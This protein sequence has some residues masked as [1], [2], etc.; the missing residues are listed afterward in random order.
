MK[1]IIYLIFVLLFLSCNKEHDENGKLVPMNIFPS[2]SAKATKT[3]VDESNII[4]QQIGIQVTN[5]VGSEF[6]DAQASYNNI[7]LSNTGLWTLDSTVY[8][9]NSSAKI[10]AYSPYSL[11]AGDLTG[12]GSSE[13]PVTRLLNIPASLPME[14]QI[15]YLWAA[16]EKTTFDGSTNINNSSANVTL[17]MNHSLAQI[18]FV[19]YKENYKGNGIISR[20]KIKDNSI[21]P[22]LRMNKNGENDLRMRLL[23]GAITGGQTSSELSVTE[24]YKTI[25]LTTDPGIDP[26]ILSNYISGYLLVVPTSI[27]EQ[28]NM[29]F[30]F[31][32]DGDDYSV[33]LGEGI[34]NWQQGNQYIYK[35]KLAAN[36][37]IITGLSV[38]SWMSNC[39]IDLPTEGG[40][41][42]PTA[43]CYIIA[44]N[45]SITIPV[46]I[47]G[48]GS[49]STIEQGISN[50]HNAHSM[51]ILWSTATN[52]I[53]LQ[54]FNITDQ[55]I[56]ISTSNAVGNALIAA[57]DTDDSTILWSWHIWVTDYDPNNGGTTY[58]FANSA[59]IT[60]TFMDR[61][62][63]ALSTSFIDD[64]NNLYYQFGRKDPFPG[65]NYS[66]PI[67]K[68]VPKPMIYA[69]Q[70]PTTFIT[71][72]SEY[73]AIMFFWCSTLSNDW[74]WGI[75][76]SKYIPKSKTIYD[77]CPTGWRVPACTE[78]RSPWDN[79]TDIN[80]LWENN[81]WNWTT[82]YNAGSYPA[83]GH[84]LGIDGSISE[85][86][87]SGYL[88]SATAY[89]NSYAYHIYFTGTFVL[90]K[91][92]I[93]KSNG[94]GIRC[95][96]E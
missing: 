41:K 71:P 96:R 3:L 45:S 69:I 4:S 63:G 29:Q 37:L 42:I 83:V 1:K 2:I 7:L 33:S 34:L 93:G 22:G 48:N 51:G 75:G 72:F 6:Y 15:D 19:I 92:G 9:S 85:L 90:P 89:S 64:Q 87:N 81:S 28:T 68:T 18:A 35:V 88:W 55:T 17:K 5:S 66:L 10:F 16:Q 78:N 62:L 95:V 26:E 59:N 11:A 12:V 77:P 74:W 86:G 84:R 58:S 40:T 24:I 70:N 57:Y 54:N 49:A 31:T 76:G 43:N 56:K 21:S 53:S 80:G 79:L 8:L 39:N 61:N 94:H 23:D 36:K 30:I 46:N 52:L 47:K 73:D 38:T 67:L 91:N 27:A 44:P 13:T 20:I 25:S 82:P 50:M 14:N 65:G 32:I 60:Y